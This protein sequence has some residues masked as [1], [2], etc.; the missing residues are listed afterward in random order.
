MQRQIC[1]S[2]L[3]AIAFS[4]LPA[5]AESRPL[6]HEPTQQEIWGS[7]ERAQ[8][9]DGGTFLSKASDHGVIPRVSELRGFLWSHWQE[10]RRGYAAYA[11][12]YID[13]GVIWHFLVEPAITGEW[14]ITVLRFSSW[15]GVPGAARWEAFDEPAVVA[16]E[17]VKPTEQ[18]VHGGNDILVL[19][20]QDGKEVMRL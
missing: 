20:A 14:H 18:D 6:D 5:R 11:S 2:A 9:D 8:Y 17:R 10:H 4:A 7:R 19:K 12:S 1:V 15:Y 3:V 13:S 16:L